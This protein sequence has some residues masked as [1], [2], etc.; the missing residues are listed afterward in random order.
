[1]ARGIPSRAS[2]KWLTDARIGY[3]AAPKIATV[4]VKTRVQRI[5]ASDA[6]SDFWSPEWHSALWAPDGT[7]VAY[8][9]DHGDL[10]IAT[11]DGGSR[12]STRLNL[13][14]G[15]AGAWSPSGRR[16][17]VAFDNG[18]GRAQDLYVVDGKTGTARELAHDLKT[19]D[20]ILWAPDERA[21]ALQMHSGDATIVATV[22]T[23]N[24][25]LRTLVEGGNSELLGWV[26]S[27][28][29]HGRLPVRAFPS[30]ELLRGSALR[31][32]GQVSEIA[33]DGGWVAGIFNTS[34]LDCQHVAAWRPATRTVVRFQK[35]QRCDQVSGVDQLVSLSQ[36]ATTTAWDRFS[37]GMSCYLVHHS[38]DVRRPDRVHHSTGDSD[39]GYVGD[40]SM[41]VP[42]PARAAPQT[43]R[44]VRFVVRDGTV[45]LTRVSDGKT[46]SVRP[47]GGVVDAELEDTGLFYA[48]N[49]AGKRPGRIV[50]LPFHLFFGP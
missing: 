38:G 17:A 42:E 50:F 32:S 5:V 40:N 7:R 2:L 35:P 11:A 48:Y 46:R 1:V 25:R 20:S 39:S 33:A 6:H 3:E 12:V 29:L 36:R 34:R 14:Y 21:L 43:R 27:T 31:A 10:V 18:A 24:G 30:P 23:A 28:G 9:R 4:D 49:A 19:V 16:L 22:A 8:A 41:R 45:V 37:C 26:R 47:S 13:A 15:A 44:G